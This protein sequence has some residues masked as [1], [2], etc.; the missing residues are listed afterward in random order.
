MGEGS[1]VAVKQGSAPERRA[2]APMTSAVNWALLGL[3]IERPSYA[4]ELAQRFERIY[5]DVLS[6]AGTSHVYIALN[7]LKGR[8]L[9]EEIPGSGTSRQPKP[10]YRATETGSEQ[11]RAWLVGKVSE[12]RRRQRLFAVQLAALTRDL[13]SALEVLAGC[14]ACLEPAGWV[15]IPIPNPK[16]NGN[17]APGH[18]VSELTGRLLSEE[19]RLAMAAKRQW[20]QYVRE[21]LEAL[22]NGRAGDEPAR[23]RLK[24]PLRGAAR[25]RRAA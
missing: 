13:Q 9:V 10:H 1:D 24:A 18:D 19:N 15:P 16:R 12:D 22:A 3:I 11:Y 25:V 6:L 2:Q 8:S 14:E 5:D 17:G 7:A 20:L 21:E 23:A 4:Y